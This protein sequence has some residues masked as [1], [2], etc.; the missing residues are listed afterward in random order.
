MM[1]RGDKRMTGF[2]ILKARLDKRRYKPSV[3]AKRK[4]RAVLRYGYALRMSAG[5][6]GDSMA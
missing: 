3:V 5:C 2:A 6:D 1:G 4:E